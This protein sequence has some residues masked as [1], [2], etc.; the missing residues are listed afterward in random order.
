MFSKHTTTE[1]CAPAMMSL[2]QPGR[3]GWKR[4]VSQNGRF[5]FH[6]SAKV[7]SPLAKSS[8]TYMTLG[9]HIGRHPLMY[10]PAPNTA[11]DHGWGAW[12]PVLAK[13]PYEEEEE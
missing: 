2:W 7:P 11:H 8:R 12:S 10:F 13:D 3:H 6:S 4:K 5:G 9:T 1:L